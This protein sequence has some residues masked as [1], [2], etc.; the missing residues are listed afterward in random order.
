MSHLSKVPAGENGVLPVQWCLENL[1]KTTH[2]FYSTTRSEFRLESIVSFIQ[3]LFSP[4]VAVLYRDQHA[5]M[6]P[7]AKELFTP[8]RSKSDIAGELIESISME[9]FTIK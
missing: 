3:K 5:T 8:S 6:G 2:M 9:S 1:G 7:I 4:I